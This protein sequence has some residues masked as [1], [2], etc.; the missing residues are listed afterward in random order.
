MTV[1]DPQDKKFD[2]TNNNDFM[3]YGIAGRHP[4][5]ITKNKCER[6]NYPD[7][8]DGHSS[9]LE[10]APIKSNGGLLKIN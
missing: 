2:K 10:C 9:P 5:K 6:P 7:K 4:G 3:L 1:N 8:K